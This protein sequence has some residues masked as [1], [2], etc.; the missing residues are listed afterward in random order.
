MQLPGSL[1]A[2]NDILAF[3]TAFGEGKETL[4][5]WFYESST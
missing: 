1:D 3:E 5:F 2:M 4:F